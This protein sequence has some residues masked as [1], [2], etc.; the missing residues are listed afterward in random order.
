MQRWQAAEYTSKIVLFLSVHVLAPWLILTECL[1]FPLRLG[2]GFADKGIM[3]VPRN[4]FLIPINPPCT[5]IPKKKTIKMATRASRSLL[6]QANRRLCGLSRPRRQNAGATTVSAFQSTG[7]MIGWSESAW[8]GSRSLR[9]RPSPIR[10]AHSQSTDSAQT[11]WWKNSN[12]NTREI[13]PQTPSLPHWENQEMPARRF[14]T[15]CASVYY[16]RPGQT[17]KRSTLISL[18]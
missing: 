16:P 10:Y 7:R 1:A 18:V 2:Q 8:S 17:S 5:D 11:A 9:L 4:R 3:D 14:S 6:I 15:L 13:R 12:V